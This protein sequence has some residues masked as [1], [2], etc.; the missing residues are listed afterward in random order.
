[1]TVARGRYSSSARYRGGKSAATSNME[2][3]NSFG[4]TGYRNCAQGRAK[5]WSMSS[6]DLLRDA[7]RT[8]S[9]RKSEFTV[10]AVVVLV[11][12][13]GIAFAA[14]YFTRDYVSRKRRAEARRWREYS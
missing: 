14:G 9:G 11:L 7:G 10:I 6:L 4:V 2:T 8:H 5:L 3:T 1:M 12:L 13:L